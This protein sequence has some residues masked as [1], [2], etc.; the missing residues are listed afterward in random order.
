MQLARGDDRG[1]LR[2]RRS[3]R[4]R[5]PDALEPAPAGA[6]RALRVDLVHAPD[7]EAPILVEHERLPEQIARSEHE[8]LFD[9]VADLRPEGR[10]ERRILRDGEDHLTTAMNVDRGSALDSRRTGG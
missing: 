3:L 9:E 10:V 7:E 2:L 4:Q 5:Q 6:R 8:I 1:E